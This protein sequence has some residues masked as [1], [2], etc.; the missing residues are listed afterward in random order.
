[1]RV[2][3]TRRTAGSSR[4]IA[5]LRRLRPFGARTAAVVLVAAF[6]APV[7]GAGAVLADDLGISPRAIPAS[8]TTR[9]LRGPTCTRR[10]WG[11]DIPDMP[12]LLVL[13]AP[14]DAAPADIPR[15]VAQAPPR[16]DLAPCSPPPGPCPRGPPA[17]LS[18]SSFPKTLTRRRAAPPEETRAI[19]LS[20]ARSPRPRSRLVERSPCGSRSPKP[21]VSRTRTI[22]PPRRARRRRIRP[23]PAAKRPARFRI[24][25]FPIR[26]RRSRPT[27]RRPEPSMA[28]ISIAAPTT[29]GRLRRPAR[30]DRRQTL[31]PP[32]LGGRRDAGWTPA[33]D[34]AGSSTPLS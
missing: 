26:R 15:P 24:R 19:V 9:R 4:R 14:V 7:L 28:T 11:G 29:H 22:R 30:R 31:Q 27:A 5:C 21:F 8:R 13:D 25:C 12:S 10:A 32:R 20:R 1:M 2:S 6:L 33:T 16:R 23:R 34:A 18:S 17:L 3:R